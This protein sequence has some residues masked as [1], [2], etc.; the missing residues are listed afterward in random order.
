MTV[1]F[2]YKS[3]G[4]YNKGLFESSNITAVGI[5]CLLQASLSY[6]SHILGENGVTFSSLHNMTFAF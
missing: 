6:L 1:A 4:I 5:T 2:A 3:E